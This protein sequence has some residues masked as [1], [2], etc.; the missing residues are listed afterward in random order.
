MAGEGDRRVNAGFSRFRL[1]RGCRSLD[2]AEAGRA[3][4]LNDR[5]RTEGA[6]FNQG[7]GTG[8]PSTVLCYILRVMAKFEGVV[9]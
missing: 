9:T 6:L 8:L 3:P 7:P 5:P 4:V 1:H 2:M